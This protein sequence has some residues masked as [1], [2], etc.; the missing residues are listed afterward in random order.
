MPAFE[1]ALALAATT[2][3]HARE[4]ALHNV[5]GILEWERSIYADA[6]RHFEAALALLRQTPTPPRRRS[7]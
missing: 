5:L 4:A 7:S 6:L 1:S 3:E 2:G